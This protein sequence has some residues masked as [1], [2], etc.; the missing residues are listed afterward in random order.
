MSHD[1]VTSC[2]DVTWRPDIIPEAT[3]LYYVIQ[4]RKGSVE[5]PENHIFSPGDLD[6]WRMTLTI[7]L[8]LDIV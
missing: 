4:D 5:L 3:V 2:Y 6:L 1:G 8:D 7:E